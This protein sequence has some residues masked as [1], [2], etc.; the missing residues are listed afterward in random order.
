L[1]SIFQDEQ[2]IEEHGIVFSMESTTGELREFLIQIE[3]LERLSGI[4]VRHK[5]TAL[6]LLHHH[7]NQIGRM[8]LIAFKETSSWRGDR[9]FPLTIAYLS[10]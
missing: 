9:P 4:K 2:F 5:S 10:R 6:A 3:V 7:R 1:M 8:C